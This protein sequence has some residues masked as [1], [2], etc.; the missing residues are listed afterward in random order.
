M[1]SLPRGRMDAAGTWEPRSQADRPGVR[2]LARSRCSM[3]GWRMNTAVQVLLASRVG[4]RG[5][6]AQLT[7]KRGREGVRSSPALDGGGRASCH[8]APRVCILSQS[9]GPWLDPIWQMS[10]LRLQR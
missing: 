1:E 4:C 8:Q 9:P 7:L 3:D 10:E 5:L 2:G 6:S